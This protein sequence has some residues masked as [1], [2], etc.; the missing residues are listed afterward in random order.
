MRLDEAGIRKNFYNTFIENLKFS[1]P[2]RLAE[3][4]VIAVLTPD[5]MVFRMRMRPED[6]EQET[7]RLRQK[8]K[9]GDAS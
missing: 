4:P 7:G 3:L 1:T 5:A 8:R 6:P 9:Q 2:A